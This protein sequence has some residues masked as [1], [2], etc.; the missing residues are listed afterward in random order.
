MKSPVQVRNVTKQFSDDGFCLGPVSLE[1]GPGATIAI[2]GKNGAG[3]STF[4]G[5]VTGNLDATSGEIFFENQKLVPERFDLKRKLGYLPQKLGFPN[6]VTATEMLSYSA[7]LHDLEMADEQVAHAL[8][9]WDC[10]DF[11]DLALGTLSHGMKKRVGLALAS[12]HKPSFLVLDEPFSGLDIIHIR[13]L[14]NLLK[15]RQQNGMTTIISTHILPF[16][17]KLCDNAYFLKRGKMSTIH[18]WNNL[19]YLAKERR[20]EEEFFLETHADV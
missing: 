6:W 8:Q 12:M 18:S 16:V 10:T 19:D 17:A 4:F 11:N 5:L 1:V 7:R 3:K 14:E 20:L 15:E 9:F 2:L 13:A